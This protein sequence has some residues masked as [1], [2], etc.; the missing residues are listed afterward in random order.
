MLKLAGF[1]IKHLRWALVLLGLLLSP[2]SQAKDSLRI[3]A[4]EGYAD[5]DIVA[6]FEQRYHAD[7]DITFVKS[8]DDLWD[9]LNKNAGASYDVFAVNTA[10]LQRYINQGL[11]SPIAMQNIG[12]HANQLPRFRDL[13]AITGLVHNGK[14]YAVPYTYSEMGL[15]YNRKTVKNIPNSMSAMWDPAY[16]GRV[17]AYNT[18]NHNFSI[19][20]LLMGIQNPFNLSRNELT[21]AA[22]QLVDLRRNVLTF[23]STPEDVVKL[24]AE[25]EVSLIY[26]NFG[27]QQVK[28]LKDAGADVGYI[29]PREGALA[30]LDCWAISRGVTNRKIAEAWINYMLEK[31]VSENLTKKHG[32]ANTITPYPNSHGSDK[33]IWLQPVEDPVRRKALWD[34]IV[35]GESRASF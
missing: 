27:G 29:I 22:K 28:A 3:L 16:R 23:Y 34:R 19:I 6:A 9:K 1:I 14:V 20:A 33:I 24:F 13:S 21:Q 11:S 12:N 32:L 25:N 10:E 4:W 8:D 5:P 15:I 26:G 2:A 31:P 7:L 30:W 18:S 17:L 35:S